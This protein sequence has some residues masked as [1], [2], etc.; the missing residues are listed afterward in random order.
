M[1]FAACYGA[2][3]ALISLPDCGPY[4]TRHV[5]DRGD[6]YAADNSG[7][8]S[9]SHELRKS[10]TASSIFASPLAGMAG[11][12]PSVALAFALSIDSGNPNRFRHQSV[13]P[14]QRCRCF[15]VLLPAR[16]SELAAVKWPLNS[17]LGNLE[18]R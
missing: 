4:S 14:C 8:C 13:S 1:S 15:C 10:A 11:T 2:T 5:K 18:E 17:A 9:T 12:S 6:K 7:F 3:P 16:T